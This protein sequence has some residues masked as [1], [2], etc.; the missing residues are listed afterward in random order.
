MAKE[1]A[2]RRAAGLQQT[3]HKLQRLKPLPEEL[4]MAWL[5][6]GPPYFGRLHSSLRAL[7]AG[8]E[9]A[10]GIRAGSK[11]PHPSQKA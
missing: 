5:K 11:N 1:A 9:P 8:A 7:T 10:C 3:L 6:P 4:V 2:I